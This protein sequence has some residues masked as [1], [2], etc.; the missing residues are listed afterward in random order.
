MTLLTSSKYVLLLG[1][2]AI[3]TLLSFFYLALFVTLLS[4]SPTKDK[5][6]RVD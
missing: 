5:L 6:T 1:A 3:L 4:I 2:L